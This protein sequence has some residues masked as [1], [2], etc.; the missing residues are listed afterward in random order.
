MGIFEP[1][2]PPE[3]TAAE[4]AMRV[5]RRLADTFEQIES[6]LGQL[7]EIMQRFGV[8]EIKSALGKDAKDV[9]KLYKALKDV[10]EAHKPD[11]K[12]EDLPT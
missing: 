10:V 6:S 5:R 9:E 2:A 11:A 8:K 7:R 1:Q 4:G 12:V 3:P